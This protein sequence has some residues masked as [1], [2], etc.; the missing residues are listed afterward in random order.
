MILVPKN[1][2]LSFVVGPVLWMKR[3]WT[4]ECVS[5]VA[6]TLL[7]LSKKPVPYATILSLDRKLRDDLCLHSADIFSD[8]KQDA[9]NSYFTGPKISCTMQRIINILAREACEDFSMECFMRLNAIPRLVLLLLHRQYLARALHSSPKNIF[10]SK[11]GP[12]V[13]ASYRSACH[14]VTLYQTMASTKSALPPRLWFLWNNLLGVS[15][16]LFQLTL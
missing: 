3:K 13:L 11:Y 1:I 7:L 5:E 8:A 10:S 6:D 12:S 15:V 9:R 14:L 2:E 16:G 4:R